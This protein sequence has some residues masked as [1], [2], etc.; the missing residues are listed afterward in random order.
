VQFGT[1]Q[2]VAVLEFDGPRSWRRVLGG[3]SAG[4]GGESQLSITGVKI[5]I[6]ADLVGF[7]LEESVLAHLRTL[8]HRVVDAGARGQPTRKVTRVDAPRTFA[9]RGSRPSLTCKSIRV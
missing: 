6:G 1:Y 7:P 2:R 3:V 5:A 8:G 4:P 9:S